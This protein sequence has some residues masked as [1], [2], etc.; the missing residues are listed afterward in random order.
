MSKIPSPAKLISHF[1]PLQA[2][3]YLKVLRML[4]KSKI[5][6]KLWHQ[7]E[8]QMPMMRRY[9]SRE[10]TRLRLLASEIFYRKTI[11][12]AQGMVLTDEIKVTL[13]AQA[14]ILIF[15][16][17]DPEQDPNLEW[18]R[19]WHEIVVY[20]TP[21]R[22]TK[23]IAFNSEGWLVSWAGI[24]AGETQYQGPVIVD[25]SSDK[26]HPLR[27]RA[28]QVLMHELSH[29]LDMLDGNTNGHPPLHANMSEK[30]WYE[31]FE[32]AYEKLKAAAEHGRQTAINPYAATNPAEFFA[33]TTEYFFEAPQVLHRTY[34][35]VYQQMK[36]FYRQDPLARDKALH[37]RQ[38]RRH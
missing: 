13:C 28:N 15:G 4:K 14:A 31:A 7:V 19:N 38:K 10:R 22:N 30:A 12:P 34:P 20:P 33:V 11:S 32:P 36:L 37:Q 9:N 17:E 25:W 21:F 2:Y 35:K 26:P 5:P 23:Q 1:R 18:F 24:E 8:S 29:K 16:L 3:Q 6:L 27:G